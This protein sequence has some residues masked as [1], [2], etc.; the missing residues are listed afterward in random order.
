MRRKTLVMTLVMI[1]LLMFY[2]TTF[3]DTNISSVSISVVELKDD[4]GTVWPA[5]V[6]TN[7]TDY[8]VEDYKW[9]TDYELWEPGKKV[10]VKITLV[11]EEL[12]FAKE[13]YL[14]ANNC[15]K[16]SVTRDGSKKLIVK[17]NYIPRVELRTPNDIHYEDDYLL[18]WEKVEYAGGYEV[19]LYKDGDYYRTITLSGRATTEIDLSE[20][21]TDDYLIT[22]RIR[23]VAPSGKSSYTLHSE[24][25]D[26]DTE[27]ISVDGASTTT[28]RFSGTG[29]TKR[30]YDEDGVEQYKIGW[31]MINGYWYHFHFDNG[32]AKTNGWLNSGDYWYLFDE[33]GHMLTG[34][35]QQEKNWY[36]LNIDTSGSAL[37][38]GAMQ[39]GWLRTGPASPYYFLNDGNINTL[40]FGAMLCDMTTLDGYRLDSN[41]VWQE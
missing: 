29:E 28:G 32:Y 2:T 30:F 5:S 33:N 17:L 13:P 1:L 14:Y 34:W 36:Y 20:Y 9:S 31:Q 4:P 8:E 6:T 35:Q 15:E 22:T 11:S 16:V 7:S 23:A 26:F 38:F 41:G 25:V 24:W 10:T 18:A 37:P 21:A 40:P 27:G 3:A 12:S 19:Q 39:T